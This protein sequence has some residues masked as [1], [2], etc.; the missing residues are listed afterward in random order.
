MSASTDGSSH[1]S[2]KLSLK[3]LLRMNVQKELLVLSHAILMSK[4]TSHTLQF[5]KLYCL[6][7][8]RDGQ[9]IPS[10]N[11]ECV[12]N[13]MKTLCVKDNRGAK[14]KDGTVSLRKLLTDFY[15][16]E[17]KPLIDHREGLFSQIKL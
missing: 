14:A 6:K 13:S 1:Q 3:W 8:L 16:A 7:C 4:I 5:I 10:T 9:D 12:L 17:Y 11:Q 2:I 15:D